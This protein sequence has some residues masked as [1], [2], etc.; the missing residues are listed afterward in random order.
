MISPKIDKKNKNPS[1]RSEKR[2]V[3]IAFRITI[4]TWLVAMATLVFFVLVTTPQQKKMFLGQL[5]SKANSV[6]LSLHDAAATAVRLRYVA[7]GQYGL[8]VAS[9]AAEVSCPAV[10]AAV[11]GIYRITEKSTL[12][13]PVYRVHRVA[14]EEPAVANEP[15]AGVDVSGRRN[16]Q[17]A[18]PAT[19]VIDSPLRKEHRFNDLRQR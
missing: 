4:L 16:G 5:E 3:G 14:H 13:L 9:A 8:V 18:L 7:R 2:S 19:T 1:S 10:A 11:S 15:V 17:V 12:D 6:S